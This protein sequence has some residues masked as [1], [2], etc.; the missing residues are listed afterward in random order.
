MTMANVGV[1][2]LIGFGA[3]MIWMFAVVA[4]TGDS[5][6]FGE[7][8]VYFA[9][10]VI[11]VAAGLLIAAIM[12]P[13]LRPIPAI[14]GWL[15]ASWFTPIQLSMT[16]PAVEHTTGE[17]AFAVAIWACYLLLGSLAIW[18]QYRRVNRQDAKQEAASD[19]G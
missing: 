9:G 16:N 3:A 10:L 5:T 11:A 14:V 18:W 12:G 4:A 1:G 17:T 8:F 19:L 7:L 13:R 2:L 15:P 6:L